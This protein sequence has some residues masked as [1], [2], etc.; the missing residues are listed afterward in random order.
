ML[1]V[2]YIKKKKKKEEACVGLAISEAML[3]MGAKFSKYAVLIFQN[4]NRVFH[5]VLWVRL[6]F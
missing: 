3:G 2:I 1:S 6:S 4:Q 5:F